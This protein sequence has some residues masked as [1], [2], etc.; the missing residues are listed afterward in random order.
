MRNKPLA[1][2]QTTYIK[3]NLKTW[4]LA[5]IAFLTFNLTKNNLFTFA[6]ATDTPGFRILL[7]C[8]VCFTL[9]NRLLFVS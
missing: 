7:S 1:G 4:R 5:C 3:Q 6:C 2:K 8:I 9:E